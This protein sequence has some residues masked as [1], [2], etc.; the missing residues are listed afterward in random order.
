MV[1]REYS[2][3]MVVSAL[4]VT[5]DGRLGVISP[6]KVLVVVRRYKKAGQT[7]S[8]V[9][10]PTVAATRRSTNSRSHSLLVLRQC[11]GCKACDRPNTA[12]CRVEKV[13]AK[14]EQLLINILART[15]RLVVIAS[16]D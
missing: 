13:E 11:R 16:L 14:A 15:G 6:E 7:D 10:D 9:A 1:F 12:T 2:G 8:T 4:V 3:A 5:C